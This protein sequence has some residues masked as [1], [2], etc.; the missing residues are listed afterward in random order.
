M[1]YYRNDCVTTFLLLAVL[2]CL[3]SV[4]ESQPR[5]NA[6][7]FYDP[8]AADPD[9][10]TMGLVQATFMD[11]GN[12]SNWWPIC[13]L[14][15]D[16]AEKACDMLL[17]ATYDFFVAGSTISARDIQGVAFC[18]E[19]TCQD[20]D[21]TLSE[22]EIALTDKQIM[23]SYLVCLDKPLNRDCW[24]TDS[25]MPMYCIEPKRYDRIGNI[26]TY[27]GFTLAIGSIFLVMFGFLVGDAHRII[28]LNKVDSSGGRNSQSLIGMNRHQS[29]K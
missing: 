7:R 2:V 15:Y 14:S 25:N 24:I 27:L 28:Q 13:E 4:V 16:V 12:L 26:M 5:I 9:G 22:C 8:P 1:T 18:M 11:G 10:F 6:L 20:S 17:P 23:T 3:A 29:N 19:I 21:T